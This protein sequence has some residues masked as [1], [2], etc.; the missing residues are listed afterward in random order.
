MSWSRIYEECS[1]VSNPKTDMNRKLV[2]EVLAISSVP[3]SLTKM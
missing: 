3:S 1:K 2:K